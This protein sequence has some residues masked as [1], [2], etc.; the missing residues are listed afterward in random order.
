MADC[1]FRKSGPILG[2]LGSLKMYSD[3]LFNSAIEKMG[4]IPNFSIHPVPSREKMKLIQC[5]FVE[6]YPKPGQCIFINGVECPT[7]YFDR[8][9]FPIKDHLVRSPY[10]SIITQ[11]DRQKCTRDL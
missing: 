10:D 9:L 8:R 7:V 11:C 1:R 6:I 3:A 2:F 5:D 4:S